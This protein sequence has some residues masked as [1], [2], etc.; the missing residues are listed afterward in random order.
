MKIKRAS[1]AVHSDGL[2]SHELSSCYVSVRRWDLILRAWTSTWRRENSLRAG[3]FTSCLAR[4]NSPGNRR[5]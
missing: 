1:S 5:I 2:H 4:V 3:S